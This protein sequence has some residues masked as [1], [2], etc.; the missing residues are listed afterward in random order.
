MNEITLFVESD[1]PVDME[2][3]VSNLNRLCKYLK[4]KKGRTPLEFQEAVISYPKSYLDLNKAI[5]EETQGDLFFILLTAKPYDNNFFWM[6]SGNGVILSFSGWRYLT[7]L[8]MNNGLVYFIANMLA[9]RIDNSYRHQVT[10]GCIYDFNWTKTG[11]DIGMRSASICP[12]CLTRISTRELSRVQNEILT[13]D[14]RIL[15]DLGSASKWN[16]DIVDYWQHQGIKPESKITEILKQDDFIPE[17]DE[18]SYINVTRS[19]ISELRKLYLELTDSEL[20]TAEKG[21]VFEEFSKRFFGLIKKWSIIGSNVNLKD[22]EIDIIYD[23]SQGPD[24]LRQRMG[25]NIYIE[26]KNRAEKSDVQEIDHFVMNLKTRGLKSGIFFSYG[27]ITGYSPDNWRD[28][29]AAYRRII[30]VFRLEH[31]LILPMVAQDIEAIRNGTNLVE[32]I[33]VLLNRFVM[34]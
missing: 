29:D 15:N 11:I 6:T 20:L 33:L 31:I 12:R 4:F 18:K 34:V 24:I 7:G 2:A 23:I 14:R 3:I 13:D 28:T 10:T 32:H 16:Q 1:L 17:K 22:C 27:G 9:L 19:H 30:D 25:D 5:V 26:C 21:K 8:S